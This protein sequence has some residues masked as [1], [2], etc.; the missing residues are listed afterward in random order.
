MGGEIKKKKKRIAYPPDAVAQAV[1]VG[2]DQMPDCLPYLKSFNV[3][4]IVNIHGHFSKFLSRNNCN[5]KEI[6]MKAAT[7]KKKKKKSPGGSWM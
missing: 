3:E 5:N 1:E 4:D 7:A 6:T 2:T